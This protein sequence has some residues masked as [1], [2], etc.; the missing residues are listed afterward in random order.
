MNQ[1]EERPVS[2]SERAN[3]RWDTWARV[4]S[5]TVVQSFAI[6]AAASHAGTSEVR[7]CK[8][9]R[10]CLEHDSVAVLVRGILVVAD[11]PLRFGDLPEVARPWF[12]AFARGPLQSCHVLERLKHPGGSTTYA[13]IRPVRWSDWSARSS[14]DSVEFMPINL[15]QSE[16]RPYHA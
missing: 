2:F 16:C 4:A 9:S 10:R 1:F 13:G 11:E 8:T 3:H 15:P 5:R 7:V 6:V 12:G 14:P